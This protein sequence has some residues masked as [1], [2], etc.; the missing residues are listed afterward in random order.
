MCL[1]AVSAFVVISV[2]DSLNYDLQAVEISE[3]SFQISWKVS[4]ETLLVVGWLDI[5]IYFKCILFMII[6]WIALEIEVVK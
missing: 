3:D 6:M 4:S 1:R 2:P 5:S